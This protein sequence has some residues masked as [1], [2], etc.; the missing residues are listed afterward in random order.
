MKN[1]ASCSQSRGDLDG[2][3]IKEPIS[4]NNSS[5]NDNSNSKS[6]SKSNDNSSNSN[7][8]SNAVT[9]SVGMPVLV[10]S[11]TMIPLLLVR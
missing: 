4:S 5:S 6:N 7:T 9:V 3:N 11:L 8:S 10:T 1:S 2:M